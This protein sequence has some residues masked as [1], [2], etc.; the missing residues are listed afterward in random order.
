MCILSKSEPI[1]LVKI[2][3]EVVA[4]DCL[5]KEIREKNGDWEGKKL[6]CLFRATN[7]L[8]IFPKLRIG[9]SKVPSQ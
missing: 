6:G 2:K 8:T 7:C 4:S 9:S 3:L 1:Y 5:G